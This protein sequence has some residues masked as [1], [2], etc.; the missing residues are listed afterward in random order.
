[1]S[2]L[3]LV[4]VFV[5]AT[6]SACTLSDHDVGLLEPEDSFDGDGN[7][8][9]DNPAGSD[10]SRARQLFDAGVY[11][12]LVAKCSGG[13]C[14]SRT[15]ADPMSTRFVATTA[16]EGWQIATNFTAVVG[17]HTASAAPVLTLIAGG[18]HKG[19][20][21][22]SGEAAQ[23]AA[24]LEAESQL[25]NGQPMAIPGTETLSQATER[26]RREFVAC[27][28]PEDFTAANVPQAVATLTSR[29][30][31][32]CGSCHGTGEAGF[33]AS[34]EAGALFTAL[35]TRPALFV[36]YFSAD[37]TLGPAGAKVTLN[38]RSMRGV[39]ET[40][41]PHGEHPPFNP[42]N[43]PAR[44]ALTEFY[45]RTMSRKAAGSC[46]VPSATLVD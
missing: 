2:S 15:A 26:V 40:Q 20:A 43:N 39:A 27:M 3:H 28:T 21:Y 25:R 23:V 19:A 46:N 33:I 41:D 8:N 38:E 32:Q 14:H 45:V 1:M 17:N 35:T 44:V 29:N 11:P 24:W 36:Q 16:N 13:A 42:T 9:G 4:A 18:V 30:Y 12:V 10:L 5:T 37:L 34:A 31:Q 22:T 7:N 6:L